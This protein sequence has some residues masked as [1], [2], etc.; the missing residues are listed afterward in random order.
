MVSVIGKAAREKLVAA[1]CVF[2]LGVGLF[3]VGMTLS[4]NQDRLTGC[5]IGYSNALADS[6]D[7]RSQASGESQAALDRVMEAVSAAFEKA[8]PA[9]GE[10]VR[11]AID[12]YV[13]YRRNVTKSQQRNPYP[14]APRDACADLVD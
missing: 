5:I 2:F 7:A 11:E 10:Q 6:L 14:A 8:T 12:D 3:V 9:A 1:V 13:K 4:A